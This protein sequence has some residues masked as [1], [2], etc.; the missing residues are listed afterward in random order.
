MAPFLRNLGTFFLDILQTVVLA[1]S[2]FVISYLFLFQPHQV[3]GNSMEPN[4]EDQEYVLTDKVSYRFHS[5]QRGDV[6]VFRSPPDP[7]RDYIKRIIGLPEEKIKVQGGQVYIDNQLLK[8]NY[9]PPG[10]YAM[11]GRFLKEG[12][13]FQI[14]SN[15]YI[16]L[17]DNRSHSSDS[18]EWGSVHRQNIV[19][20]AFLRYWPLEEIETIPQAHYSF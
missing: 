2:L 12:Q 17:G 13:E 5:P 4:F 19:G 15:Y 14:P 9:L 11:A 18:R 8:E 7:E 3:I 20:K 16:V 1:A 6:V 10:S